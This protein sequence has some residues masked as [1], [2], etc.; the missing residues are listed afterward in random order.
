MELGESHVP[1]RSTVRSGGIEDEEKYH[2]A[3]LVI[4]RPHYCM[5]TIYQYTDFNLIIIS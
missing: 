4:L 2:F 3:I 1:E 5:P